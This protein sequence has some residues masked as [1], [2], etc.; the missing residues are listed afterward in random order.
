MEQTVQLA[1]KINF[2]I[3]LLKTVQLVL[4]E[5]H[6]IHFKNNVNN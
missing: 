3:K 1:N 5:N 4:K 6:T 2:I